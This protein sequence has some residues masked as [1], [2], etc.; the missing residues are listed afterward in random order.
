MA[1]FLFK[2]EWDPTKARTNALKHGLDFARAADIFRD[3]LALTIPDSEHS[4]TEDRWITIGKDARGQ[5]VLLVHTFEQLD[6]E[7]ARIRIISAR[8]PTRTELRD[9]DE[10]K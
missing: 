7:T 9:Y 4:T 1:F 2:F 10:P 5:S 8:R 6:E 3:P